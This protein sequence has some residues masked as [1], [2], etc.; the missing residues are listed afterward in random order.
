MLGNRKG[1]TL[2]SGRMHGQAACACGLLQA[3]P[4]WRRSDVSS[5]ETRF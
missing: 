3:V 4:S 1:L 2:Q 5:N